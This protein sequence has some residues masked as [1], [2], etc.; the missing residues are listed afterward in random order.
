MSSIPSSSSSRS[1]GGVTSLALSPEAGLRASKDKPGGPL[2]AA[3]PEV[4][5]ASSV[6]LG[7]PPQDKQENGNFV[8]KEDGGGAGGQKC[9]S[10]SKAPWVLPAYQALTRQ[11][12]PPGTSARGSAP[13]TS[14]GV[15]WGDPLL[16]LQLQ[17]P[18]LEKTQWLLQRMPTGYTGPAPIETGA[19][20]EGRSSSV[21][22]FCSLYSLNPPLSPESPEQHHELRDRGCLSALSSADPGSPRCMYTPPSLTDRMLHDELDAINSDALSP[23][24]CCTRSPGRS[25]SRLDGALPEKEGLEGPQLVGG[26]PVPSSEASL[27]PPEMLPSISDDEQSLYGPAADAEACESLGPCIAPT[28]YW[29]CQHL[30]PE[31][32]FSAWQTMGRLQQA[33]RRSPHVSSCLFPGISARR[34][35]CSRPTVMGCSAR[36]VG[37]ALGM[38]PWAVPMNDGGCG[39]PFLSAGSRSFCKKGPQIQ[40]CSGCAARAAA[41]LR[42]RGALWFG[43]L[44]ASLMGE[45]ARGGNCCRRLL[46]RPPCCCF[47]HAGR[48]SRLGGL[49]GPWGAS[50]DDKELKNGHKDNALCRCSYKARLPRRFSDSS[51]CGLC[52]S[53]A[54]GH[55]QRPA[56]AAAAGG[57]VP[58]STQSWSSTQL[59]ASDLPA[60]CHEPVSA[61][62]AASRL[63][64]EC[65]RGASP[66]L[67][68]GLCSRRGGLPDAKYP[69]EASADGWPQR[70]LPSAPLSCS[71]EL[72][73]CLSGLRATRSCASMRTC[74]LS[75]TECLSRHHSASGAASLSQPSLSTP[76]L[77]PPAPSPLLDLSLKS[78]EKSQ[79]GAKPE[80]PKTSKEGPQ[81]SSGLQ[82]EAT[83]SRDALLDLSLQDAERPDEQQ[84]LHQPQKHQQQ[85]QARHTASDPQMCVFYSLLEGNCCCR[86]Q[87]RAA[88][89]SGNNRS[90]SVN[91]LHGTD[92]GIQGTSHCTTCAATDQR[93][94]AAPSRGWGYCQKVG[95]GGGVLV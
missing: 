63:R 11:E 25:W 58:P 67:L 29:G 62:S 4:A 44:R 22:D 64:G 38:H 86:R 57:P 32:S 87:R 75:P 39:G 3:A 41:A 30:R 23:P 53:A 81:N 79:E 88:C 33:P 71:S 50:A 47:A 59:A 34:L 51:G 72:Q 36:Q 1:R 14:P 54:G 2:P 12:G 9:I 13:C 80:E 35:C 52:C 90:N 16:P 74:S 15:T 68:P 31:G 18:G 56:A 5:R 10:P 55:Q 76:V 24:C 93:A 65:C 78:L 94:A 46:I 69:Q 7:A 19:D 83:E 60:T 8:P 73:D 45:E 70:P 66:L 27:P 61:I 92:G 43:G 42:E 17:P 91:G 21:W 40:R 48:N 26:S 77:S 28:V 95:R 49:V 85:Q 20:T 6:G 89:G 84:K 37:M 82:A